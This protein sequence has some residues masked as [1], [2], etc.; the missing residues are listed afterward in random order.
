MTV[1]SP[2]I[3]VYDTELRASEGAFNT[4]IA[5]AELPQDEAIRRRAAAF[6][7]T[8]T[9]GAAFEQDVDPDRSVERFR[10]NE[11]LYHALKRA[12]EGDAV[13]RALVQTN[14]KTDVVERT[15]KSGFVTEVT[16]DVDN[17]GN[18]QQYGQ[19]MESIQENSLRFAANDS[20]MRRR[21]E[22]ETVNSFRLQ[23]LHEAGMLED[24]CFVVL[25][26]AADDMPEADMKK[27]GFFTDT[28]SCAI[29]V[30][31]AEGNQIK[32]ESAFVAGV[33]QPGAARHDIDTAHAIAETLGADFS[34]MGAT[35]ML[36][37]P[38]L[39]PK[40]LLKNGVLDIVQLW[41]EYQSDTF[42]GELQD[43]QDYKAY[44]EVCREREAML[45]PKVELIT[46]E[47]ID[48]ADNVC[49]RVDAIELLSKISGR[50]MIQQALFDTSIKPEVFGDTSATYIYQARR[51]FEN[52]NNE[53]GLKFATEAIRYD[54]SSS[55]PGAASN[56]SDKHKLS[57]TDESCTFV[58]KKCPECGAKNVLTKVTAT[59][60][61]GSCGCSKRK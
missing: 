47:L 37:N 1:A 15:I 12:K 40:S 43:Q 17:T 49:S 51:E 4:P 48:M 41:D 5:V 8:C 50:H 32:T 46:Q 42:F 28:M 57:N 11:S 44:R 61:S 58:S 38:I 39:V 59:R 53:Q 2:E 20:R 19:S 21:V 22:A 52:G 18:I 10:Q 31:S 24:Y 23:R 45:E 13:A 16:L 14:V 9:V 60:I 36:N 56:T 34:N 29:Q 3:S 33:K 35:D 25:S 7:G 54:T 27:A 6:I 55:C 26:C 30:T